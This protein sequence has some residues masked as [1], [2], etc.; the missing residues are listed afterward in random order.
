MVAYQAA[1]ADMIFAEAA[2][3]LATY[4]EIK[5]HI[6]IPLLANIT[7][8]GMTPLF[9]A[10]E[11]AAHGVDM[12]L[13]PLS[14]FRAMNAA[15]LKKVFTAIKQQGTQQQVVELMQNRADLY[16][17]LNYYAFEEK[18]DAVNRE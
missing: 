7:E 5:R 14:A 12:V 17:H 6:S 1:G 3:D 15:A 13:Y 10:A 8:F 16:H 11:L 2:T 9:T 18:L 4:Q